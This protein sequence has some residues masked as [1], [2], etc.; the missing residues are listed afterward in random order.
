M[1]AAN[2]SPVVSTLCLQLQ[3]QEESIEE[4]IKDTEC[5]FKSREKEYQETIDQIE[6]SLFP[7]IL[8]ITLHCEDS[9]LI[10]G[11]KTRVHNVL[12]LEQ[13]YSCFY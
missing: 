8:C 2:S 11:P 9:P 12:L 5:M 1:T 7:C 6:A 13:T 10:L 4:V 3:Q